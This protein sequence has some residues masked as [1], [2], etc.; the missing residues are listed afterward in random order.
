MVDTACVL[1]FYQDLSATYPIATLYVLSESDLSD[2]PIATCSFWGW[3]VRDYPI[4]ALYILWKLICQRLPNSYFG[5]SF[6]GW[7]V[8]LPNSYFVCSFWGWSA[9]LPNSYMFFLKLI[10]QRD[11]P[12]ATC[13]FWDWSVRDYP[14]ATLCVLWR[15]TCVPLL[16]FLCFSLLLGIQAHSTS[17]EWFLSFVVHICT[18]SGYFDLPYRCVQTVVTLTCHKV[19]TNSGHFNLSRGVYKQ[20]SFFFSFRACFRNGQF[21]LLSRAVQGVAIWSCHRPVSRMGGFSF[22]IQT[23]WR[24]SHVTQDSKIKEWSVLFAMPLC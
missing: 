16:Q 24:C 9:R 15:L 4:A 3:S 5:C 18:N 21:G 10:C 8:R 23:C 1:V 14:I 2:Y 20:W 12:V 13:S 6:W 22:V 7:S 11:Y 17:E 19:C